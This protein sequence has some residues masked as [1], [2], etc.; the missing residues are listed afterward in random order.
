MPYAIPTTP[1]RRLLRAGLKKGSAWRTAVALGAGNEIRVRSI[2]GLVHSRDYSPGLY[3]NQPYVSTGVLTNVKPLDVSIGGDLLY[4]P[5]MI[6]T[7]L[8][9]LFGTA[10]TPSG[11]AGTTAYTHTFQWADLVAGFFTL[12]AEFPNIIYEVPSVMPTEFG[13]KVGD[14]RIQFEM[15]GRGNTLTDASATN[16]AAQTGAMTF[17][18]QDAPVLFSHS[19]VKMNAASGADV[20][21]TTAFVVSGL[22]ANFKRNIDGIHGAGYDNIMQPRESGFPEIKLK[23]D[24]PR[25]ATENSALQAAMI[26]GTLQKVLVSLTSPLFAGTAIPY[27]INLY[28]P[29]MRI[30]SQAAPWDEIVKNGIELVA[31]Q[32]AAAPTGMS[33]TRPYLVMVNKQAADYLA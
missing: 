7:A 9:L 30:L 29:T 11:P 1:E 6:G 22:D 17:V 21:G 28:F 27:S 4:D 3:A 16:A 18:G 15:K 25:Y 26:A 10:G 33:Y 23:L 8:A 5:G 32:A 24:F 12:A 20:A 31:E 14:G 13:L 19:S 2:G